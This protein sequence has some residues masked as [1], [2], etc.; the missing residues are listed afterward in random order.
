MGLKEQFCS[1]DRLDL[2]TK[3][4]INGFRLADWQTQIIREMKQKAL[5]LPFLTHLSVFELQTFFGQN[6]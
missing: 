6:P 2:N 1:N 4:L 3:P 5:R